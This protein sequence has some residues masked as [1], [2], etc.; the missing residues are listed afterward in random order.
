MDGRARASR[1]PFLKPSGPGGPRGELLETARPGVNSRSPSPS[2]H[3]ARARWV[4]NRALPPDRAR[5]VWTSLRIAVMGVRARYADPDPSAIQ[6]LEVGG[7]RNLYTA[8]GPFVFPPAAAERPAGLSWGRFP[9]MN[10]PW[11]SAILQQHRDIDGIICGSTHRWA[12]GW[13]ATGT[14]SLLPDL[15]LDLNRHRSALAK[16]YM[17]M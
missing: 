2:P 8:R 1:R 12:L 15:R 3:R 11:A 13:G 10:W 17:R 16:L 9:E 14:Y 4:A 7:L 5:T 6:L